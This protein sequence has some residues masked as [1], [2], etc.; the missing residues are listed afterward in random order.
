MINTVSGGLGKKDVF[1]DCRAVAA[2][3][4]GHRIIW[5]GEDIFLKIIGGGQGAV[6]IGLNGSEGSLS[7][8]LKNKWEMK[9][10]N[11]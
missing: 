4:T 8:G 9:W 3:I 11:E 6:G 5:L 2:V 10:E 1:D 7:L